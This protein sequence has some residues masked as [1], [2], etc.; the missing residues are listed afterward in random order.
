[1]ETI[2]LLINPNMFKVFSTILVL[3]TILSLTWCS[4]DNST[5]II[6]SSEKISS[7]P[8]LEEKVTTNINNT[9]SVETL[10]NTGWVL[11]M[12][13][14]KYVLWSWEEMFSITYP[15]LWKKNEWISALIQFVEPQQDKKD[16]FRENISITLVNESEKPITLSEY[17][18]TLKDQIVQWFKD[19]NIH[20]DVD[21]T[22]DWISAHKI[23]YS[24]TYNGRVLKW[25]QIYFVTDN[26]K[27]LY[28]L[29][30]TSEEKEFLRLEDTINSIF[31]SFTFSKK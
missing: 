16:T 11:E 22:I 10:L 28:S 30:F 21:T 1:M 3:L 14:Y 17:D 20:E 13:T 18:T 25:M 4:N 6:A 31:K 2:N 29:I 19:R 23:V 9:S 27:K 26:W 5:K 12:D 24:W 8:K 15:K 7:E